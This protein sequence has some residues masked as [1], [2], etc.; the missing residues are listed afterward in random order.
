MTDTKLAFILG[1]PICALG[2]AAVFKVFTIPIV[3]FLG[4]LIF[5]IGVTVIAWSLSD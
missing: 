3:G 4:I 1:W 2:V 5:F